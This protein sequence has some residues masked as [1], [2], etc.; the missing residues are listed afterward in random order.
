[1]HGCHCCNCGSSNVNF[2][3]WWIGV[4]TKQLSVVCHAGT[5]DIGQICSIVRQKISEMFQ[6]FMLN[7]QEKNI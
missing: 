4:D 1:M 7:I 5:Q 3:F 2:Y 6:N